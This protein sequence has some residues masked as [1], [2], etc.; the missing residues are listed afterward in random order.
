MKT[1]ISTLRTKAKIKLFV[2]SDQSYMSVTKDHKI[3][4]NLN[5]CILVLWPMSNWWVPDVGAHHST[6]VYCSNVSRI[7]IR[8]SEPP[9]IHRLTFNGRQPAAVPQNIT[10][11]DGPRVRNPKSTRC[12]LLCRLI[13]DYL[14]HIRL[15]IQRI[16]KVMRGQPG[17][18]TMSLLPGKSMNYTA[19]LPLWRRPLLFTLP[20]YN[21]ETSVRGVWSAYSGRP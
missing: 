6:I 8:S 12:P 10:A 1:V 19:T 3:S 2:R 15:S 11:D 7:S 21:R 20:I 17:Y 16:R 13:F 5:V 4:L 9:I 18:S 14:S